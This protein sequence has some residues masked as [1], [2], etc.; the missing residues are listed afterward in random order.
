MT[1][2]GQN[3]LRFQPAPY[4]YKDIVFLVVTH[5]P[6]EEKLGY[7]KD[8]LEIVQTCLNSMRNRA[9][10]EHTFVVW[11]NDSNSTFRDWL[12]HIFEPDILILSKNIGKNN[13]RCSAIDM[14]PLGSIVCY[15]DDDI[16]Y[17]DNWLNPQMDLL[18]SYPNVACVSGYP[19][20]TMFRWGN[21]NTLEWARKNAKLEQG[22][23]ISRE[24]E[25]DYADSIGRNP[26]EHI[27]MTIKDVDYRITYNN[28]QAYATAHHCQFIG[29]TVKVR[30]AMQYDDMAMG[31][32]KITDINLDK[33]G[34]RLCTTERLT[35]HMGNVLDES[36]KAQLMEKV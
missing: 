35:R 2:I 11:D 10:R 16:Y 20:R 25:N 22:Q 31:D 30:Q 26:K 17:Y 14:L 13:A 1:R 9:H 6:C 21:I 4:Q 23:F 15:S 12:Q 3:P 27:T 33:I 32:E 18:L 5:L 36:L 24:W 29:Y 34:L 7:H 19:V 28:K 8:R